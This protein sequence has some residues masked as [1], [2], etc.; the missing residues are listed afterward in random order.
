MEIDISIPALL[1]PVISLLLLTYT[2]RFLTTGQL[3]RSLSH[4]QENMVGKTFFCF[5][6]GFYGTG[7]KTFGLSLVIMSLSFAHLKYLF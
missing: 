4:Q 5:I 6:L 1:F 2:N 3:I 7:K